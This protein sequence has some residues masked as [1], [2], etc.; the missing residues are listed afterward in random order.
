LTGIFFLLEILVISTLSIFFEILPILWLIGYT[1]L[2]LQT[3]RYERGLNGI[4]LNEESDSRMV[5]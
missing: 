4:T 5:S 2:K 3:L 1:I